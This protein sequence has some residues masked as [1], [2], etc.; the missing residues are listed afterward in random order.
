MTYRF[1]DYFT[2]SIAVLVPSIIFLVFPKGPILELP[3]QADG[4]ENEEMG[5]TD[6]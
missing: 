4:K 2:Y 6:Q 1:P 5:Q 3:V